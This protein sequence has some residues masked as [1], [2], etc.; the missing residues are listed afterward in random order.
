MV[1]AVRDQR[2]DGLANLSRQVGREHD[3]PADRGRVAGFVFQILREAVELSRECAPDPR[4]AADF[5]GV[6][7]RGSVEPDRLARRDRPCGGHA[8]DGVDSVGV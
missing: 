2:L 5:L 7:R 8:S 4:Q 3:A 6:S 1:A